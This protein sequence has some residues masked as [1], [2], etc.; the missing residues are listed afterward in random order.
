[1]WMNSYLSFYK[2]QASHDL[3]CNTPPPKLKVC[4]MVNGIPFLILTPHT[5][6]R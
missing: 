1:M 5:D 3:D 4:R 6:G 2:G